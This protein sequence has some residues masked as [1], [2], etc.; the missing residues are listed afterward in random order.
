VV[1]GTC[2]MGLVAGATGILAMC[3]A[4]VMVAAGIA[5]LA[6][7]GPRLKDVGKT[8]KDALKD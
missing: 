4:P 2:R 7:G 6:Y 1:D 5:G 3:G 8:V